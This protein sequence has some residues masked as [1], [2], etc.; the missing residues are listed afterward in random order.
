M[1]YWWIAFLCLAVLPTSAQQLTLSGKVLHAADSSAL[2][3]VHIRLAQKG[4]GAVSDENGHFKLLMGNDTYGDT[5]Q[6]TMLG[7]DRADIPVRENMD[8][9]LTIYLRPHTFNM[10]TLTV[11]ADAGRKVVDEAVQRIPVNY[12]VH[13]YHYSAFYRQ[14]HQENDDYVRLLEADVTI[15]DEGFDP[16]SRPKPQEKIAVN[17]VRRSFVYEKNSEQHGDHLVD[18]LGEDPMKPPLA[19]YLNPKGREH[20]RYAIQ[21]VTEKEGSLY[22]HIAFELMD[23]THE[24][25]IE[26]SLYIQFESYAITEIVCRQLPNPNSNWRLNSRGGRFTWELE[27]EEQRFVY[28]RYGDRYYPAAFQLQYRHKLWNNRTKSLDYHLTESFRLYTYAY[29]TTGS[30]AHKGRRFRSLSSLYMG[31][32]AYDAAFWENYAPMQALPLEEKIRT[33]L[34]R[35]VPL[36]KQ[37]QRRF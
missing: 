8:T 13:E 1:P 24:H 14:W 12:P 15:K 30:N 27:E 18:L 5:L 10:D 26:G 20:Y 25:L 21:G 23:P 35:F 6:F 2:P 16:H 4:T 34:E 36:E 9:T 33:D 17:Q 29:D 31:G 19:G 11:S 3:F 22:Y 32:P 7:F 37:F 28:G